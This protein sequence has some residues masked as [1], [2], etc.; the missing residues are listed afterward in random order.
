M[1]PQDTSQN[2]LVN[3]ISILES[4]MKRQRNISR[5]SFFFSLLVLMLFIADI[6]GIDLVRPKV[7]RAQAFVL[8]DQNGAIRSEWSTRKDMTLLSMF[9]RNG[10][11][12]CAMFGEPD[13]NGFHL[14]D[15]KGIRRS[16]L[17]YRNNETS[18]IFMNSG[19][20]YQSALIANNN[21]MSAFQLRDQEPIPLLDMFQPKI[22]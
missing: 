12:Q 18:L 8:Q 5:F 2:Q 9:D 19:G 10:T 21:G 20:V 11:P 22:N 6:S 1:N 13:S 3:Q 7:I 14:Y 15:E 4:Q 16:V 17:G